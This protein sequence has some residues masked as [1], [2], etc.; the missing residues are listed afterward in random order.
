M[1]DIPP[2]GRTALAERSVL[3][4]NYAS[5]GA[6]VF[7]ASSG[8]PL[9]ALEDSIDHLRVFARLPGLRPAEASGLALRA[10]DGAVGDYR[11]R[12]ARDDEF[13]W[14]CAQIE[15]CGPGIEV[16]TLVHL[17]ALALAGLRDGLFR[18]LMAEGIQVR[19]IYAE[20]EASAGSLYELVATGATGGSPEAL[21]TASA[22]AALASATAERRARSEIAR[23]DPDAILDAAGRAVGI[24]A[25]C[26]RIGLEEAATLVSDLRLAFLSGLLRGADGPSLEKL[27]EGLGP[28]SLAV[29][30]G[31]ASA[32]A[33][34]ECEA[35]RAAYLR[36][37]A[38]G[39]EI[40]AEGDRCSRD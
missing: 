40:V 10:A 15:D 5:D 25:H 7:A 17:P 9:Y 18:R 14:I 16:S 31:A 22:K 1:D 23:R 37:A 21:S 28:G 35:L 29:A 6:A 24:L 32:P 8:A 30:A 38:E 11:D 3:P 27:L 33:G 20:E 36:A 13:G 26:R 34:T 12:L 2:A 39:I 4:R 19:G